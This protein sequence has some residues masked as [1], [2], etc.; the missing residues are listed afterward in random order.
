MRSASRHESPEQLVTQL[1]DHV[2]ALSAQLLAVGDELARPEGL[3]AARWLV[4]GALQ[5]GPLSPAAIARRRGLARQSV[6]ESVERLERSGHVSRAPG[7]DGRTFLV[8]LTKHGQS[9]LAGIEP[10]RRSW[11]ERTASAVDEHKLR[12]AVAVLATL[13]ARTDDPHRHYP[14]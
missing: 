6:R 14:R 10:R 8:H 13:R 11:A 12:D 4:L 3:S 5:D 1:V 2:V 7:E 9:A